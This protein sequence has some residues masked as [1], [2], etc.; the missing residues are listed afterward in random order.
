M[1]YYANILKSKQGTSYDY[2]LGGLSNYR[3]RNYD[4]AIN[5]YNQSMQMGNDSYY[6]YNGLAWS[7]YAKNIYNES[8][9]NFSYAIDIGK[10]ENGEE[11]IVSEAYRGRSQCYYNLNELK[12][13]FSDMSN[14]IKRD[15]NNGWLYSLR[16]Q[17][18][19][20]MRKNKQACKDYKKACDLGYEK[21]CSS[22]R[23][24]D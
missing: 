2:Y 12:K 17:I 14:A 7:Y 3:S 5:D 22:Y 23:D 16:G 4:S 13:A 9:K 15:K 6:C 20:G 21:A 24:C 10:K 1:L 18:S 8:L 19:S 11:T